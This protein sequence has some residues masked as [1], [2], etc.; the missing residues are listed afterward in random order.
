MDVKFKASLMP[1]KATIYGI[2]G[3]YF[4]PY[5][6]KSIIESKQNPSFNNGLPVIGSGYEVP[7]KLM[8]Y[9]GLGNPSESLVAFLQSVMPKLNLYNQTLSYSNTGVIEH[10]LMRLCKL[11]CDKE[12]INDEDAL[13]SIHLF[14]ERELV[15]SV[16]YNVPKGSYL[17]FS[18]GAAL[19]IK[20]NSALRETN[21][22]ADL[23]VPPFPNDCGSAI[24]AAACHAVKMN[25]LRSLNW[26]VYSGPA[27]IQNGPIDGWNLRDCSPRE[28]GH[29]LA[30]NE[31]EPIVFLYGNAE[32]GPRALGHRSIFMSPRYAENKSLLN[33][34]KKREAFRPVAPICIE[35]EAPLYF[36]PGS[37][38]P[39]MLFDHQIKEIAMV[40]GP[41]IIHIDNTARLQTINREQCSVVYEVLT[42]FMGQ[43]G[44][45]FICNTSANFNGK[46]FF[47][48]AKSA[49]EW[50]ASN[51]VTKVWCNG[52]LYEKRS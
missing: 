45:P 20:W 42:S 6:D 18:G 43:T 29:I 14:L 21:H 52:G 4:G 7:G 48:D 32:T 5:K 9:I 17:C 50:A 34:F 19:N 11:F 35:E 47:P 39:Y 46:G 1:L 41:A 15:S 33:K 22:F 31:K 13:A 16:L 51:G 38:D 30:T 2:M 44:V 10:E 49:C 36:S 27:V 25:N 3:Y 26:D 28:V 23:W 8:S 40:N 24:G 37:P 12:G